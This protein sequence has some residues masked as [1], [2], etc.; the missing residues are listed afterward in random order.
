MISERA[1]YPIACVAV[2]LGAWGAI[3]WIDDV[4]SERGLRAEMLRVE[5]QMLF[6]GFP[7]E[8][9][10]Q[11][12][13]MPDLELVDAIAP[14][15]CVDVW[16]MAHLAQLAIVRRIP[17]K[18]NESGAIGAVVAITYAGDVGRLDCVG[19]APKAAPTLQEPE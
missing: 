19:L 10:A 3:R 8:G 18:K 4:V 11:T 14:E 15:G 13:P 1:L 17:L 7:V 6:H 12:T 2:A 5:T 16:R 9:F